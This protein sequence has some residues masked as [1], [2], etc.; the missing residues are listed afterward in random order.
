MNILVLC[1][2]DKTERNIQLLEIHRR[3]QLPI[4][5]IE[6]V[7]IMF[8]ETLDEEYKLVDDMLF[9]QGKEHYMNILDKTI[10]SLEYFIN[11]LGK[12]YDFMVRTNISTAFNYRLL[13]EYLMNIPKQ[14]IYIGGVFFK[15]TWLDEKFNI[16]EETKQQY[17]LDGLCFFQGTCI[18]LSRDVYTYLLNHKE[19]LVY[20]IIDDVAIGLFIRTYLPKAYLTFI[21]RP[22]F[23]SIDYQNKY[24]N[25]DSVLF[26]HKTLND[27]TDIEYMNKTYKVINAFS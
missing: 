19:K 17:N 26:R 8:D 11:R 4:Q 22:T 24:Y 9:I 1:I 18:I 23:I 25:V 5:N 16:T 6:L 3:N 7:Y 20:E 2:F 12:Q 21:D 27:V 13:N 10:Q 15:L 14:N